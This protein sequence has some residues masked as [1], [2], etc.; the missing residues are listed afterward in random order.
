MYN[1]EIYEHFFILTSTITGCISISDFASLLGIPI[2]ITSSAIW[3]KIC[4]IAAT[5]KKYESIIKKKKKKHDKIVLLSKKILASKALIDLNISH[6]EI[7]LINNA[8][9]E[10]HDMKEEIKNLKT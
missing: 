8:L 6:A 4:Q 3:L 7:V 9:K 10:Y 1:S 2:G 5:I